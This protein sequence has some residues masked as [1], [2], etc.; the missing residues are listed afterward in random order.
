MGMEL[1]YEQMLDRVYTQIPKKSLE[2]ERFE[3]PRVESFIQGPKTYVK[4]FVQLIKVMRREDP[5][6]LLKFLTKESAA[7]AKQEGERLMIVGKFTEK[8]INDWFNRFLEEFV[9]CKEC[10]KPDTHYIE[11]N[12]VRQLKCEACGAISPLRRG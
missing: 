1:T 5:K 6:D 8:Q 3:F 10:G 12:G 4:N 7:P 11:H 2:K 9:L